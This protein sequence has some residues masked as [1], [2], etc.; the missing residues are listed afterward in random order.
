M[1]IQTSGLK[2]DSD[3]IS[4]P[5]FCSDPKGRTDCVTNNTDW[6]GSEAINMYNIYTLA[7]FYDCMNSCQNT[8]GCR[9]FTFVVSQVPFSQQLIFFLTYEWAK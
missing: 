8:T 4:G 6:Y 9:A 7:T 3:A 5:K 1:K 2:P